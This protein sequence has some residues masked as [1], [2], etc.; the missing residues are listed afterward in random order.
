MHAPALH[1]KIL[2]NYYGR[3]ADSFSDQG[4]AAAAASHYQLEAYHSA[5]REA[6]GGALGGRQL[7]WAAAAAYAAKYGA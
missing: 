7:G 3:L 5:Q 4:N 2:A 6:H 1:H